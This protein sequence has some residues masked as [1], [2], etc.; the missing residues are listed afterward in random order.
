MN[1]EVYGHH[2][3]VMTIAEES[4]SWPKRLAAGA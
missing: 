4:T 1:K 2:P 3:G